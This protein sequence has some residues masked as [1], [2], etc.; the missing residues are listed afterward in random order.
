MAA[1]IFTTVVIAGLAWALIFGKIIAGTFCKS[2]CN[3]PKVIAAGLLQF[4][5][6][7]N[8]VRVGAKASWEITP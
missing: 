4:R 2:I 7:M 5:L 1:G 3:T 6:T 8:L